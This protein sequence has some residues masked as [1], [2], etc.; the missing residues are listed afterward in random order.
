MYRQMREAAQSMRRGSIGLPG[1]SW[2]PPWEYVPDPIPPPDNPNRFGYV[3]AFFSHQ[4]YDPTA[5]ERPTAPPM[6]FS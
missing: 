4:T 1:A 5:A 2:T 6:D 3:P